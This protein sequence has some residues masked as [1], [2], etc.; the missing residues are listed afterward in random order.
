MDN[1]IEEAKELFNE[2]VQDVEGLFKEPETAV[3]AIIEPNPNAPTQNEPKG[4]VEAVEQPVEEY[5]QNVPV[6]LDKPVIEYI[7][8]IN[9]PINVGE[10]AYIRILLNP[11]HYGVRVPVEVFT[12]KVLSS[13]ADGSF[14]TEDSK[15]TIMKVG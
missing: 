5:V 12:S 7:P 2:A 15:Y 9:S 10:A 6:V 11:D 4:V 3:E 1:F 8:V 13:D 14:E